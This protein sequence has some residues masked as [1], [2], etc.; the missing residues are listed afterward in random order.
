[1]EEGLAEV[2]RSQVLRLS[3]EALIAD[4]VARLDEVAAFA[5]LGP[6]ADWH[7]RLDAIRFPNRNEVWRQDLD[8]TALETITRVQAATLEAYGYAR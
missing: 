4:P 5:G 3:Y 1:M 2:P 8:P 6:S 7:R